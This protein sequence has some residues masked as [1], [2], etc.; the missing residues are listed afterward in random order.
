MHHILRWHMTMV[1]RLVWR[2]TYATTYAT[3]YNSS[4]VSSRMSD[5]ATTFTSTVVRYTASTS[6]ACSWSR[7]VEQCRSAGIYRTTVRQ[8]VL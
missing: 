8:V 7:Y 6:T 2:T 5:T 4:T 3:T 1:Y